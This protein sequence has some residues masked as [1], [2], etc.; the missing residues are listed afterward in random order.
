MA[1]PQQAV[2]ALLTILKKIEGRDAGRFVSPEAR[3]LAESSKKQI[4]QGDVSHNV[5]PLQGLPVTANRAQTMEEI[6]TQQGATKPSVAPT[7][8]V[9]AINPSSIE[10][11]LRQTDLLQSTKPTDV[12][13]GTGVMNIPGRIRAPDKSIQRSGDGPTIENQ[14]ENFF[15][16]DYIDHLDL[17]RDYIA[18]MSEEIGD[19]LGFK[20]KN[21]PPK[22]TA[23]GDELSAQ[24]TEA[25]RNAS[26]EELRKL[27][28]FDGGPPRT[29]LAED[30]G[31]LA[32][33]SG[34][35][36]LDE[37]MQRTAVQAEQKIK[38]K[39]TD[40][41]D[42]EGKEF[43]KG[44]QRIENVRAKELTDD[45]LFPNPENPRSATSRAIKKE[46][47]LIEVNAEVQDVISR[48]KQIFDVE[49]L[50]GA[51]L[52]TNK[53]ASRLQDAWKKLSINA[54]GARAGDEK[55]LKFIRDMDKWLHKTAR[56]PD[57]ANLEGPMREIPAS[58]LMQMILKDIQLGQ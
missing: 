2:S 29:G 17:D 44:V 26:P 12:G 22:G 40:E 13:D 39:K 20:P 50:K 1:S 47:N 24:L 8:D 33:R 18:D 53:T 38:R 30:T 52:K 3:A 57:P 34:E 36:T 54:R 14:G 6:L 35:E 25:K 32:S 5:P 9:I 7:S 21:F 41:M 56:T 43:D 48:F 4:I 15:G 46:A 10:Q 37:L 45:P 58:P 11:P 31:S 16:D 19:I 42:L 51:N 49:K 55:A 23:R 27:E 28:Q